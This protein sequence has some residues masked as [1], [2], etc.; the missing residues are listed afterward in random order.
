M[1]ADLLDRFVAAVG[2]DPSR[3]AVRDTAGAL[4]FAELDARS[5]GLAG[6]LR[7]RGIG[8]GDHVGIS[9]RRGADLLVA[10]LATW[11][12]GAAYVPMDP[13]YPDD[14]LGWVAADAG[15]RALVA[16]GRPAWLPD[17]VPVLAPTDI[18]PTD[19]A[20]AREPVPA[21]ADD[22]A[23]VI[24]TSGSTGRPKGVLVRR[25]AVANLVTALEQAGMYAA[26]PRVVAWNASVSFDAS[27]QQ[28]VRVCRGDTIIVLAPEHR[29]E[30]ARLLSWLTACGVTDLDLTPSHWPLLREH[31]LGG[32]PVLRLFLGGE[33]VPEPMW[34]EIADA[35][36]AGRLEAVNLY[37]PT[38][39][40][41]DATATWIAGPGG[42]HIGTPLTGV[43]ARV[44]DPA[45][46]PLPTGEAGELYL[47][48]PR[49]AVGYLGRP[50]LTGQR[51]VPDPYGDAGDRMYRTGDRVRWNPDGVLEFCGRTDRQ[52]KLRGYRVELDEIEAAVLAHPG[53]TAAAVV[54]RRQD[55]AGERLVG[56]YAG[57]ADPAG[58]GPLRASLAARLPDFMVPADLVR[59]DRLPLTPNGKLDAAALPAP[60]ADPV[61]VDPVGAVEELIAG[62]W[63]EVLGRDRVSADDNFFALGG[64]SLVALRVV[65]RIK[66]GF[67]VPIATQDVYR[68]P[69]LSDLARHVE[70]L[71]AR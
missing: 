50:G 33:P 47:S 28:W 43:R 22:P 8:R 14:R 9:L 70:S 66:R 49:L 71:A 3:V 1:S 34:R 44:L 26:G 56:Y 19:I 48:G 53:V 51:F 63:S 45:L 23:Y 62:V 38:E 18:A 61:G 2:R 36:A 27:V 40:T 12:A 55:P 11:R 32:G 30:P 15:V 67:G 16:V 52:V 35:A 59:L 20:P 5:A 24:H 13:S 57:P 58:T 65:A 29:T 7:E 41:V 54:V 21:P 64:H 17:S 68:H 4:T 42:P 60:P 37:G 10:L 69:T 25:D 6:A 46:R 39:C 31:L